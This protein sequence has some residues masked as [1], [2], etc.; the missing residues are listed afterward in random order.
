[1]KQLQ[2]IGIFLLLL[3]ATVSRAQSTSSSI[4][5][6]IVTADG[7][8][9]ELANVALLSVVDSTFIQG[10][11]S[12][13]DG[14]FGF[15]SLTGERYMLQIS[16]LGY[17]TICKTFTTGNV[18]NLTIEP[19]VQML[20][21]TVISARRP[22][23]KLKGSTLITSV[24][25]TL[26]STVGTATD[27]LK[28]IP[29]IRLLEDAF[30]VFGK[31]TPIIYIDNHLIQHS[32]ELSQLSSEEVEKIELI[33]NPGP[34]YDATAKAVIR[35]RTIH[36]NNNGLSVDAK[37]N[38]SH[39]ERVSHSEQLNLNYR[40]QKVSVFS[41][42]N[43]FKQQVKRN[44]D[45]QYD[46]PSGSSWQINSSSDQLTRASILYGKLGFGYDIAPKQT[47]GAAYEIN[48]IPTNRMG[49][50][51][52]YNVK[53]NGIFTDKTDYTSESEQYGVTHQANA[54]YQGEVKRLKIDFASDFVRRSDNHHQEATEVSKVA[55]TREITTTSRTKNTFYAAKIV[56]T[57][58]LGNGEL[59]AG[60]D[61]THI[62]RKDI[63]LNPQGLLPT[64]DSQIL[65]KK[66][67]GFAEYSILL[68]KINSSVGLR[69]EHTASDYREKGVCIPEQSKTYAD[70]CPNVSFNL[71]IKNVETS[72]SYNVK[73][74]RPSLFQLRSSLNYNNRFIYEGGNPLLTPETIH[75]V[76]LMV[77]YQWLHVS[78]SY[79]YRKNAIV[80]A[81]HNHESNPDA[82]IFTADNFK[83]QQ[84]IYASISLSPHF[85][86]WK[87]E[88]G[89]YFTQPFFKL[90][91]MGETKTMNTPNA[92]FSWN[93]SFEL[94]AGIVLSLNMN[95]QTRGNYSATY[96]RPQG[97]VDTSIRKSFLNNALSI[98][99]Q[100]TDVFA[101]RR[102]SVMLYGSRL[103]YSKRSYADTRQFSLTLRYKFNATGSGYKGKHVSDKDIQRL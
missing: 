103:T 56:L 66:I 64:T 11:C 15:S 59:K 62:R 19:E 9:V 33:S 5:G 78:A 45:V 31:G 74:N 52:G 18:G 55:S 3:S 92:Y 97:G 26:L 57:H 77:L 58:P 71:P 44:Q 10:T 34:E 85:K 36:R 2:C 38:L 65:E 101:T 14:S 60:A 84:N 53:E 91:S 87:P 82:V 27:I 72:L 67:A 70:W 49:T 6:K 42:F 30:S 83:Q 76:S 89:I 69:F 4:T 99:L 81:T 48:K 22:V 100:A 61:Y 63:F 8:P 12:L 50:T 47:V 80:F 13:P 102:T 25:N 79:Q 54:F 75:D 93:N 24:P 23:Y 20:G 1:M 86:W 39:G 95:Y 21:E 29:G 16:Y 37:A 7:L 17:R 51:S 68:G 46:I 96:L 94:P 41:S 40:K 35:I 32:S 28:H 43:Y 73:T 90:D 88:A 98:N